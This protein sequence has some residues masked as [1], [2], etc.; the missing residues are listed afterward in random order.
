MHIYGALTRLPCDSQF[1]HNWCFESYCIRSCSTTFSFTK[2]PQTLQFPA[3]RSFSAHARCSSGAFPPVV[4]AQP[5]MGTDNLVKQRVIKMVGDLEMT[6]RSYVCCRCE[7]KHGVSEACSC[8]AI[9]KSFRQPPPDISAEICAVSRK[10]SCWYW[11][12]LSPC[13]YL[14][15]FGV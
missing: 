5:Y 13:T 14:S 10:V 9:K 2:K 3:C 7:R 11:S 4:H 15:L 6:K 8:S 1:N 12:L